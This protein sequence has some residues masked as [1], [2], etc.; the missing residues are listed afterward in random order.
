MKMVNSLSG[1]T[2]AVHH[3][4][5]P[6]RRHP[7][8]LRLLDRRNRHMAQELLVL[9]VDLVERGDVMS[10]DNKQVRGGYWSNIPNDD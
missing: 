10:G 2:A 6:A 8:T 1:V 7:L 4:P 5:V 3:Q 9:L